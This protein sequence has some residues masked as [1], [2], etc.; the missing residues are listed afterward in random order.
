MA[1][2]E[3]DAKRGQTFMQFGYFN[4]IAGRRHDRLDRPQ[5]HSVLQGHVGEH[6]AC[7]GQDDFRK[8]ISFKSR[9]YDRV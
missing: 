3:P 6:P 1:Y 7:R 2:P 9:R 5:H 8:T 4:G